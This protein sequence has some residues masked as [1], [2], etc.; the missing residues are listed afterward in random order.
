MPWLR[1]F[2]TALVKLPFR[3]AATEAQ[4]QQLVARVQAVMSADTHAAQWVLAGH[5]RG[6]A[7]AARFA[8]QHPLDIA[9]LILIATTHPKAAP[10][11][12]AGSDLDVTKIYAT[13]DGLASEAEMRTTAGYLPASTRWVRIEGGNHAQFGW[14][15]AQLGDSSATI[16]RVEQQA[17]LIDAIAAALHAVDQRTASDSRSVEP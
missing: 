15:G 7:L 1:G 16:S 9:G 8:H 5:S 6:G 11:D 3:M 17:R 10:D 2:P 13:R 12:L 4:R 14:Y